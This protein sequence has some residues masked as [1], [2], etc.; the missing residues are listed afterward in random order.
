MKPMLKYTGG[1]QKEI[2][3]FLE[4]IPEKFDTYIEPFMGGGA[5]FFHLEPAKAILNDKNKKLIDFYL[6][7][8][9]N[10]PQLSEE[11][12]ALGKLYLSNQKEYKMRKALSPDEWVVNANEKLYYD[13]RK[14]FNYPN[15]EYLWGTIYYFINKTAYSGMIRYNSAGE[16]NISYG[17]YANFNPDIV[18]EE[19]SN[20]LQ[21]AEIFNTDYADIFAKA[22][23]D[24]FIFL[25]PPYDC[26]FT[27]YGNQDAPDGFTEAEQRRLAENFKKLPCKA[28][29]VISKT[30]L[31]EELYKDYIVGEYDKDYAVNI[32][33]R[34]KDTSTV[35]LIIKNY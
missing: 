5:V 24:D 8:R 20:L 11:L 9:N 14:L 22:K 21:R 17:H 7:V 10:Y 16:F 28:M 34:V 31:I 29:M 15:G 12:T 1:K 3:C 19:H 6:D 33:N 18:T 35:H 26:V 2:P 32:R 30:P 25:D 4:H 13:M 27:K 23:A